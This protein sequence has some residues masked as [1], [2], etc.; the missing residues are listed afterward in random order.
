[1][2]RMSD[3]HDSA[4][5]KETFN[6]LNNQNSKLLIVNIESEISDTLLLNIHTYSEPLHK[7]KMEH[8]GKMFN[9]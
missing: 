4:H 8:F 3:W 1:M 5:F 9:G 2:K 7:S 6:C